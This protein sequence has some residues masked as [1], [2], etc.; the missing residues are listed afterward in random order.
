MLEQDYKPLNL[1]TNQ[2]KEGEMNLQLLLDTADPKIWEELF[3]SG[4]FSGIT[5]NPSL[6]KK[7]AQ[8]CTF[9]NIKSLTKAAIEIS[10]PELH[11]Q[12]WGMTSQE[13]IEC[14]RKL[15]QLS[16]NDLKVYI[17]IPITLIGTIAANVLIKEEI[18]ITL[19][20]CFNR[21]QSLIASRIGAKYLAPYLN[22]INN[23]GLNGFEEIIS[24]KR[25]LDKTN[26]S[27]KLLIASIREVSEIEYL[28]SQG[29]RTFAISPNIAKSIFNVPA[30]SKAAL[31]F[32]R[33]SQ[34]ENLS[35][36]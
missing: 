34:Q 21:K 17:K 13:I 14:A 4:M 29:L 12:A 2:L 19:T 3:A 9:D 6:L 28:I 33:D 1:P 32:E 8:K 25:I 36:I 35:P 26:S 30:T 18:P 16:N 31:D 5:T 11:L 23:E 24:M 27:C 7:A 22:R 10:C 20:A 15:Y